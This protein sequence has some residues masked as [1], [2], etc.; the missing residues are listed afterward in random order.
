MSLQPHLVSSQES[1]AKADFL[2][3]YRGYDCPLL[4]VIPFADSWKQYQAWKAW[5]LDALTAG[6]RQCGNLRKKTIA[7]C[8]EHADSGL[9]SPSWALSACENVDQILLHLHAQRFLLN[10]TAG[11]YLYV[12]WELKAEKAR[13]RP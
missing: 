1:P 7:V 13:E 10:T 5:M 3:D 4:A 12:D 6:K 9:P 8:W 2:R 11:V